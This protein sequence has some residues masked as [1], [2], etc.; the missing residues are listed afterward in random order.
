MD[1][2]VIT[3]HSTH[4]ALE[5]ERIIKDNGYECELIP[6]P[7]QLSVSCGLAGRVEDHQLT[8]IRKLLKGNNLEYSGIYRVQ[9]GEAI[10]FEGEEENE[11]N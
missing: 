3:F 6:V 11:D 7:R 1:V 2:T 10:I 4:D 9:S 5:C 8:V